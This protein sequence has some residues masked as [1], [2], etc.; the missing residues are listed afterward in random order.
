MKLKCSSLSMALVLCA[1]LLI[2][3]TG[4]DRR[5]ANLP[6]GVRTAG[7]EMDDKTLSANVKSALSADSVKYPDV[8]VGACRGVVQLSGFVD[9]RDQMSRATDVAKNVAG[10]RKVE[11]SISVKEDKK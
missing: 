4:C 9:S 1:P 6:E 10:V 7:E 11:N 3:V 5:N 8:K 2:G